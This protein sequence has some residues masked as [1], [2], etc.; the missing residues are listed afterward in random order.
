MA[1]PHHPL[2]PG[3]YVELF[4]DNLP[5]LIKE[6]PDYTTLLSSSTSTTKQAP[7]SILEPFRPQ[8]IDALMTFTPE[9]ITKL[10][11]RRRPDQFM[12]EASHRLK[13]EADVERAI[14]LYLLHGVNQFLDGYL[15]LHKPG[16]RLIC[17]TQRQSVERHS[18]VDIIWYVDNKPVLVMEVKP[19]GS[20]DVEDWSPAI[21]N[22]NNVDLAQELAKANRSPVRTLA[23]KNA[24][25]LLKQ[26]AK[27]AKSYKVPIVLICDWG[28]LIYLDLQPQG[29]HWDNKEFFP[30]CHFFMEE[31]DNG[32]PRWTF[33]K[34]VVAAF[35][36]ALKKP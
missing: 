16:A 24:I 28:S 22:A 17:A 19:W 6:S 18:R 34:V 26:A 25:V 11:Q 29:Y 31:E 14:F 12:V 21:C 7:P 36:A 8:E 15:A 23:L 5:I 20:L 13:S 9:Q 3:S 27:Y 10:Y 1:H 32:Q 2:T 35:I 30:Q 33:R 4:N